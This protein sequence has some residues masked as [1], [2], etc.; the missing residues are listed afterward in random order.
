ML[1][2]LRILETTEADL[3]LVMRMCLEVRMNERVELDKRLSKYN[4][5]IGKDVL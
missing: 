3:Q 4:L 5:V 2:K 1:K